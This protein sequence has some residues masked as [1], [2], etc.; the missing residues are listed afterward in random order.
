[1]TR[2][3]SQN[4]YGPSL[5]LILLS[6]PGIACAQS[7]ASSPA[8][9]SDT[10]EEV[11]VV[12]HAIQVAPSTAPLDVTQPTSRIEKEFIQNNIIPLASFDDMVKF[13]PSVWDQSPNGPGLGKSEKLTVRG[14]QDG[15]FNVTFDGIPFGD[16][17]DLHHTSSA[18]F[19][20]H[21]IGE[22]QLD[23][24]PGT[25]STV[26]NATFGGTMGF[27]TKKPLDVFTANAYGTYGSY[28]TRAF[29]AEIDTGDTPLG[30]AFLDAQSEVSDGYLTHATERRFNVMF[31]DVFTPT[32]NVTVT[33]EASYNHAFEYTTQGT[34]LANIQAFGP[35]YSL[36]NNPATQNYFG[37]QPSNYYSDFEYVDVKADLWD[38]WKLQNTAYTTSFEHAYT[39]S[40]DA[41]QTS[42]AY[43]GV[44]FYNTS[45]VKLKPQPA[46]AATDIPGK[47]TDAFFRAYGD[48]VRLTDEL[49]F[50]KLE[51]GVWA[52]RNNDQRYSYAADLTQGSIPVT[53]KYG[54]Q[55]TYNINDDL[56]TFQPYIEFDWKVLPDL[57]I[58]PGLKYIDVSRDIDAL[59][60]KV[61]PP[62]PAHYS[63]S[64]DTALPSIA[65]NYTIMENWTA[66]VQAAQGFLAPPISVLE[67]TAA[68]PAVNPEETWNY[69]IGTTAHL[70]DWVIGADVYYIDFS[71]YIT[72]VTTGG[73]TSYIN[74]GGAI[75]KGA[76]TEIQYVLGQGYSLYGNASYN[77]AVYKRTNVQLA[78]TPQWTGALGILYDDVKGP[79]FSIIS[80][81]IGSRYG[82]DIAADGVTRQNSIGL[83][84][85]VTA[86]FAAGWRFKDFSPYLQ[87]A[88]ISLKVSNIFNNRKIDDY[89][90]TQS[91]TPAGLYWTVAGRSAFINLSVSY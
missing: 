47:V 62:A 1:M 63:Q 80:K 45:G 88:S 41:S 72:S 46:S 78:E 39:E 7:E 87:D 13:A 42:A 10:M 79:Y 74:G 40:T 65:A 37:Y 26:G 24:G 57:T 36:G 35:N 91:A 14:F 82:L 86:D 6:M 61:K 70:H 59:Y 76:E 19:I 27:A 20:A 84:P 32:D 12:G 29:G 52:E 25:A 44:T 8:S 43:N 21:D 53:G 49:S 34:T 75:Y 90:G 30:R 22:V 51:I 31:K 83:Q 11:V 56:I 55:Y 9:P 4:L 67:V 73:F 16:A 69:Q 3:A 33:T 89:A 2:F 5:A 38:G 54:T 17:T 48:I 85:Y 71:N 18:V 58:T 50:G 81:W 68:P 77:N 64:F 60:N 66:Y 23:R 28:D 15:Q